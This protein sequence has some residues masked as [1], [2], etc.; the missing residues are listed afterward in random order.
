MEIVFRYILP[1]RPA[2]ACDVAWKIW[3]DGTVE[4]ELSYEVVPGLGD[5]PEF[6]LMFRLYSEYDRVSWYGLGP[7]ENYAD[8]LVGAKLGIYQNKAAENMTPYLRPQE[9]GAKQEVRYALVQNQSGGGLCF[10][11]QPFGL[12]VTPYTPHEVEN[13]RHAFELPRAYQTV[14]RVFAG[15]M[16]VGGDD[17]WG[18]KTHPEYLLDVSGRRK[19]FRIRFCGWE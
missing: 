9:S 10:F 13:A 1:T 19:S 14:V 17:S 6:G 18:A 12:S 8:R 3:A 11:G 4:A 16:G 15:Q 2:A 7:E 5:M